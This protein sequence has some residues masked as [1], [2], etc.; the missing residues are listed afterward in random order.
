MPVSASVPPRPR[1]VLAALVLAVATAIAGLALPSPPP[2]QA[3]SAQQRA[4]VTV[5]PPGATSFRMASFNVLGADHTDGRNPRKGFGTS[6]QR[7]PIAKQVLENNGV[8][9]VGFQELHWPQ[10]ELWN[11]IAPE[12]G[13]FP[14]TTR[15]EP[16]AHNSIS[17]RLDSFTLVQANV[18]LVPYFRGNPLPMPY[19][20]LR[21]NATG[22]LAWFVNVHNPADTHGPAQ[23]WRDQAVQIESDLVNSLRAADPTSPVFLTG[24]MNDTS[25]FFC[26]IVRNTEL[27]AAN[28]G[29]ADETACEPP[30]PARI[31]W[32]MGTS[33]VTFSSFREDRSPMVQ[34]ASDHP[35]MVATATVPPMS[36]RAAGVTNVV[37]VS[38]DGLRSN[39]FTSAALADRTKHLRELRSAGASTLNARLSYERST[40]LPN[41]LSLLT[42]RPVVKKR[43]GHG[44]KYD[45]DRGKTLTETAGQYVSSVFDRVHNAGRGTALY[46]SKASATIIERS[47]NKKNGGVDPLGRDNG[48]DKLST[49]ALSPD[50]DKVVTKRVM[51]DL[52]TDPATYSYVE[53]SA[54][55]RI[56]DEVKYGGPQYTEAL[57]RVDK[58]VSGIVRTV[59]QNPALAGHTMVVIVG[60]SAGAKAGNHKPPSYTAPLVVSGP[61]VIAGADLY[62][63]NPAWT[64]PGRAKVPY[65]SNPI[66][67]GVVAN[68]TL[69]A[70]GMAPLPGSK[71]NPT[72]TFNVFVDGTVVP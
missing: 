65:R 58:Q 36:S 12:W 43:D 19:V 42:G 54:L 30:S 64:N 22:Q 68:L 50:K 8:Q 3:A 47:W 29:Y 35:A 60:G 7:L 23:Q 63:L 37:V 27:Q 2:A 28:G 32:L 15:S 48:R 33:D 69:G 72:S 5:Q 59:G 70:L 6:A 39:A 55:Q 16:A 52:R 71:L 13:T 21:N 53:L 61:G 4:V 57:G 41:T 1:A 10:A 31:D 20:Q 34:K 18:F 24:D 25:D 45:E 66:F 26:P 62:D 49:F 67:T 44:V 46:T 51:Q 9:V 14:G 11:G 17:W 40:P 56:G 38:V